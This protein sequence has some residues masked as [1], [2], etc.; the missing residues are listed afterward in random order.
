MIKRGVPQASLS[1]MMASLATNTLK[2]YNSSIKSWW[3]YCKSNNLDIYKTNKCNIISFLTQKYE[4]GA[5]YSSLNTHRSALSIILGSDV[6]S[7]DCIN[8]FLKG[9]FRLAPPNPKYDSTWNTNDVL[10]HLSNIYPYENVSLADLSYKTCTLL[11]IASAQ[12]MQT[13]S[14][15]KLNNI[16]KQDNII[17]IKITDLIKTSRPGA[18]Q[19]LIRL[20]YIH[21]NP[22]IC[23]AL[24]VKTYLDKTQSLRHGLPNEHLF[25]GIRKPHKN[26]GSQTLAHWVKKILKDSG[27]DISLFGAHSTRSASTSAAHRSGV[28]LEVVR[29]AA[30]WSDSSNVFL[31]YYQRD[32]RSTN[33]NDFVNGVF[34]TCLTNNTI[35]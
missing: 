25:I 31:K 34:G 3:L 18:C 2:Q 8:R 7:N 21:E 11:A 32:I 9:V 14:S 33:N 22:S 17:M 20:P 6:T 12:R 27:I 28:N 26:V 15:I 16:C 4:E 24:A 10:S 30:G 19:P 1:I 35:G 23:P 5:R 13:I 29:K